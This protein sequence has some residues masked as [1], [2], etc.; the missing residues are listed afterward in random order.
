MTKNLARFTFALP[1]AIAILGLA[2]CGQSAPPAPRLSVEDRLAAAADPLGGR[3]LFR[4]C[5]VCHAAQQDLPHRVGPNLWGVY[6]QPAGQH[7]DFAYSRALLNSGVVWDD[8]QLDAYLENP[9]SVIPGGRMAYRGNKNPA[10][11]R[12]LIAY[13]ASLQE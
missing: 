9:Q 4:E 3:A 10:D 5:A 13:L 11:R 7:G 1:L 12:D 6:G 8:A 2:G